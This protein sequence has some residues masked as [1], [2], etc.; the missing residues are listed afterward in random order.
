MRCRFLDEVGAVAAEFAAV[1]PAVVLMLGC[2]LCAIELGGEQL[3]L[4]GATADAARL[5]GRGDPGASN[6]IEEVAPEARLTVRRS[7]DLV[8]ADV[9]APV[10]LGI[11]SGIL[12]RALSCTL[13][14]AQP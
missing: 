8:C 1:L 9:A 13:D 4:Q 12:L 11:L 2:A 10:S 5:L 14:D 6:R 7:G 3:R